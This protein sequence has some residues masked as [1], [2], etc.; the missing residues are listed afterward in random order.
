MF[1]LFNVHG[2]VS[3]NCVDC[4]LKTK[5]SG[6]NPKLNDTIRAQI[7]IC[8]ENYVEDFIEC[9]ERLLESEL[10]K[11]GVKVSDV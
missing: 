6:R 1:K 10:E 9:T 5:N 3:P 8:L 7:K 4:R 2:Q 11:V